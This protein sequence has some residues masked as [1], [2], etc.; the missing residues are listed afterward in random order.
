MLGESWSF[1]LG[2]VV[3]RGIVFLLCYWLQADCCLVVV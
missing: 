1:E 3:P 2:D